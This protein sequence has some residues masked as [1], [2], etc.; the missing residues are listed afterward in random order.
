L[1]NLM[2]TINEITIVRD[3]REI[4]YDY[5][6]QI[7][8]GSITAIVG[9]NGCG[10][11]TLLAAI[12]GEIA[13]SKGTIT[14]DE[15]HPILTSPLQLARIRA[16]AIQN[17]KYTLGFT[18]KQVIEM[19]GPSEAVMQALDLTTL[20]NRQVTTLS[21]GEAQRV[22]I[23]TAI[24]QNTPVLLLDEPLAA[25]DVGSRRRIIELLQKLADDGV[26]VVVVAHSNES[27]LTWAD[28]VIKQFL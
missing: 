9:P 10:K 3:G 7:P 25:Q 28:K 22:S 5:S 12:A 27:E 19:A 21:G 11:S 23:A 6:E 1:E 16:V 15:L 20:A 13:P 17:Q 24:A 14:I 26:S 2:I 18:V 4:I 8:A